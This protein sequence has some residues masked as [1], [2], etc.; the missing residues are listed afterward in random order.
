MSGPTT[1]Y[2]LIADITGY[3]G[4]LSQ[5]ELEHA[6]GILEADPLWE[7]VTPAQLGVVTF[8]AVGGRS[9]DQSRA[10]GALTEDGYAALTTTT[11]HGRSVLRLCTINPATTEADLAGTITRLGEALQASNG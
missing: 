7:V 4:F 6:Q 1:G 10:A 11:L 3:T 2:L 9:E 8:A 5:T